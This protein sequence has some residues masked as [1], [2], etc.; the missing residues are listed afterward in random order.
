MSL[1]A[2]DQT[3]TAPVVALGLLGGYLTARTTG[4]RPLGGVVFALAGAYAGRTWLTRG[5]VVAAGLGTA[6]A[7]GMGLSHPLARKIGA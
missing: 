1:P 2:A 5:P 3:R 6:Y 7:A 4:I